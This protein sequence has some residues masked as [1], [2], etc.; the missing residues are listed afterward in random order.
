[1][2][3]AATLALRDVAEGLLA[4]HIWLR[5]GWHDIK[6]RYRR[7]LLGPFWLTV[8]MAVFIAAIGILYAKFF[9]QSA[10]DFLPFLAIGIIVWTLISTA[11]N[12]ACMVF[13][14]AAQIVKQV[15]LPL[16]V[17]VCRMLYRNAVI[18]LHNFLIVPALILLVGKPLSWHVLSLLVG[19][20]LVLWN[21]LWI[22]LILA[23]ASIRF[24]DIPP[25]IGSVVQLAFFLS[26]IMWVPEILGEALWVAHYNPVFHLIELFRAP[27]LEARIPL[28]SYGVCFVIA[29]IGSIFCFAVLVRCRHRVAYWI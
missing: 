12:E 3:S 27:V 29:F 22:C 20:A 5:L 23:I 19:F 25:V 21:C 6:Q 14:H 18:F 10:R 4:A 11:I 1:M 26:P 13:V 15:K 16:T 28:L 8:S 24:R 9:N 2:Q 7:S 17:H